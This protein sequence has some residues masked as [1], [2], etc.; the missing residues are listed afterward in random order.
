LLPAGSPGGPHKVKDALTAKLGLT[1][2]LAIN[3]SDAEGRERL[4]YSDSGR[5]GGRKSGRNQQQEEKQASHG[6]IL[7]KA[8][9]AANAPFLAWPPRCRKV[10]VNGD[11]INWEL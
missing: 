8:G 6:N 9:S 11:T 5:A 4:A 3:G 7:A 1:D 2:A 10:I